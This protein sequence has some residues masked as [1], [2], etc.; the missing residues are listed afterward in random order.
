MFH[1]LSSNNGTSELREASFVIRFQG[2]IFTQDAIM[3]IPLASKIEIIK[4]E[5]FRSIAGSSGNTIID[6]KKGV[7][8]T[9]YV[10]SSI[11]TDSAHRPT[12]NYSD[13]NNYITNSSNPVNIEISAYNILTVSIDSVE[14]NAE[15]IIVII[16]YKDK[17]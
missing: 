10:A 17:D 5:L 3:S 9:N 6:V 2:L 11:F 8:G 15:D 12:I 14:I 13:G 16:K 7:F 1:S 4:V